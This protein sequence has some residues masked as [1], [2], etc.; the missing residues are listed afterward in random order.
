MSAVH[1]IGVAVVGLLVAFQ[2]WGF[3]VD[4]PVPPMSSAPN[5]CTFSQEEQG[6][7]YAKL[8]FGAPIHE[9]MTALSISRAKTQSTQCAASGQQ[10]ESFWTK[11]DKAERSILACCRYVN[12]SD[13]CRC[14]NNDV[15]KALFTDPDPVKTA[16]RWPDDPCHMLARGDTYF[17]MPQ[18]LILGPAK[19]GN[20]L[21]YTSHLHEFAFMHS[22]ASSG[23]DADKSGERTVTTQGRILMWLEIAFKVA[24]GTIPTT[25]HFAD[26]AQHLD[27]KWAQEQVKTVFS[28][29]VGSKRK[30]GWTVDF[31]F[32]GIHGA[33]PAYV[34]QLALGS[35]LH[36]IQD[37]FSDSHVARRDRPKAPAPVTQPGLVVQ[38][39]DYKQQ[40]QLGRH[41]DAD[42]RPPDLERVPADLA[43]LHPVS[44][45]AEVLSCAAAPREGG[46]SRWQDALR[47]INPVYQLHKDHEKMSGPG[48]YGRRGRAALR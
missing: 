30:G 23:A 42:A 41:P 13:W 8:S 26:I 40:D 27:T 21:A 32:T 7:T 15:R 25:A 48:E 34:R 5:S 35:A 31:F 47:V 45:G 46:T 24:D 14:L 3:Q 36:T 19:A 1:K 2:T 28:G 33:N 12:K 38:F 9:T 18:W 37:A 39:L 4:A 43:Q 44:V 20:N 6:M 17:V 11:P 29:Y 16:S 10:I 22:M